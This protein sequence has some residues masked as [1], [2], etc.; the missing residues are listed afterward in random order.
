MGSGRWLAAPP[1]EPVEGWGV[2]GY[3]LIGVVMV[4][5]GVHGAL[6][7]VD[8]PELRVVHRVAGCVVAAGGC[9]LIGQA[10]VRALVA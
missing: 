9:F 1:G 7:K 8:A 3:A 2:L 4:V 5:L 10:A 6:R